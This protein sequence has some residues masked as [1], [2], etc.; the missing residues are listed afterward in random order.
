RSN[1]GR[2]AD[3]ARD[4]RTPGSPAKRPVKSAECAQKLPTRASRQNGA[5]AGSANQAC[6]GE[7]RVGMN[8]LMS[9]PDNKLCSLG[10]ECQQQSQRWRLESAQLGQLSE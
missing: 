6:P 9:T 3:G 4:K 2:Q 1:N 7:D 10:V 5:H 8:P